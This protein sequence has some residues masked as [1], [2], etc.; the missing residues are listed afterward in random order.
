MLI[1]QGEHSLLMLLLKRM[2]LQNSEEKHF[3]SH[4]GK[5]GFKKKMFCKDVSLVLLF[6]V[7]EVKDAE[8]PSDGREVGAEGLVKVR[9]S[10]TAMRFPFILLC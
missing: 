7:C 8:M 2:Q 4:F 10:Y 9:V 6:L 1:K 3:L 5:I